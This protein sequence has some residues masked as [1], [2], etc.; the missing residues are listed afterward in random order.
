MSGERAVET[1]KDYIRAGDIFQV[2]P[3]AS[4]DAGFSATRLYHIASTARFCAR[5]NP[6]PFIVIISTSAGFQVDRGQARNPCAR[7]F[8]R[9]VHN[10][11][12]TMATRRAVRPRKSEKDRGL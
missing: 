11:P 5:T 3:I 7:C 6:S 1:A 10:P 4:A 8:G 9:E 2:V 12:P